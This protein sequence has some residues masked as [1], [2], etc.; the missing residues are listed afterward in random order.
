MGITISELENTNNLTGT[1]KIPIVQ[2]NITK[3]VELLKMKEYMNIENIEEKINTI[4]ED[5]IIDKVLNKNE[6]YIKYANGYMK[7]WKTLTK[8]VGGNL[9]ANLYYSEHEMGNWMQPFTNFF[10]IKS[11]INI[12]QCWTTQA[13]QSNTSAG[14]IRVYRPDATTVEATLYLEANGLW[15]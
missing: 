10:G 1:E 15:K 11:S 7:Q 12:I 9:W 4:N 3:N 5:V 6:G 8:T 13:R 2:D 14:I